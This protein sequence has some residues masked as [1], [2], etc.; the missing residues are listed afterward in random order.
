MSVVDVLVCDNV[1]NVEEVECDKADIEKD[2][3]PDECGKI[4]VN[5]VYVLVCDKVATVDEVEFKVSYEEKETKN[6]LAQSEEEE[7]QL[8]ENLEEI[9]RDSGPST[10][11]TNKQPVGILDTIGKSKEILSP[12]KSLENSSETVF[13]FTA[14]LLDDQKKRKLKNFTDVMMENLNYKANQPTSLKTKTRRRKQ[15]LPPTFTYKTMKDYF[16]PSPRTSESPN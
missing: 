9:L 3:D 8:Q 14:R 5:E 4:L 13:K 2:L 12:S 11:I 10:Q 15:L 7:G 16:Q 1:A 6:E